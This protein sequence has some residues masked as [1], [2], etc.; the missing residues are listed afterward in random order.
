ML[1]LLASAAGLLRRRRVL[2]AAAA[3]RCGTGLGCGSL[4]L[5]MRARRAMCDLFTWWEEAGHGGHGGQVL[6]GCWLAGSRA[7]GLAG[8]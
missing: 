5:P 6:A 7:L 8:C 4:Y 3:V 1:L 2:G